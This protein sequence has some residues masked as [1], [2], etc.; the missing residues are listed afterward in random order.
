MYISFGKAST[1]L[2]NPWN[3][4]G[5]QSVEQGRKQGGEKA[6]EILEGILLCRPIMCMLG[7]KNEC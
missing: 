1:I 5:N 4:A 2:Y 3:K 7:P 6:A